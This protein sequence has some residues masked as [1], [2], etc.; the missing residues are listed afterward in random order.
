LALGLGEDEARASLR[1]GLSRYTTEDEIEEA[2]QR[3]AV[4]VARLRAM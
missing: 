2:A 4:G 3:I 1:F